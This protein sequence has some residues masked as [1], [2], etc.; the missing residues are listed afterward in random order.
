MQTH[1]CARR[2]L[3]LP[4]IHCG[5]VA[6]VHTRWNRRRR[7]VRPRPSNGGARK[8]R[9]SSSCCRGR[10]RRRSGGVGQLGPD[11]RAPA[12]CGDAAHEWSKGPSDHPIHCA[13]RESRDALEPLLGEELPKLSRRRCRCL[14]GETEQCGS[15]PGS[16]MRDCDR[17]GRKPSR[18]RRGRDGH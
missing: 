5:Y 1:R 11:R 8:V 17:R 15:R 9:T 14:R 6:E 2:R 4:H 18:G 13:G 7:R 12:R 3:A 16:D 10:E